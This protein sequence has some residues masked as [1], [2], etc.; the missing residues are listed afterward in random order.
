V[1]QF[2][3]LLLLTPALQL[4]LAS[5]NRLAEGQSAFQMGDLARAEA[6]FREHLKTHPNSAEALSN[7]GAVFARRE[8]FLE[9]IEQYQRA[10]K[11]DPK[12]TPVWFNLGVAQFRASRF[13]GAAVS[14]RTFLNTHPSE[15]R[16]RQLLGLSLV[17]LG[18]LPAGIAE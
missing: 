2:A 11:A 18:D 6:L 16:A 10:L 3:A 13:S 9:A 8:L 14:F 5:Q 17:E 1:R 15:T 12:L 4:P 7:L